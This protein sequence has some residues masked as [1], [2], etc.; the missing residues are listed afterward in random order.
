MMQAVTVSA[1]LAP[2][3]GQQ[4]PA[5]LCRGLGE[6]LAGC[7]IEFLLPCTQST[8]TQHVD[9]RAQVAPGSPAAWRLRAW[10]ILGFEQQVRTC[11]LL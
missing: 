4:G 5:Q 3:F 2:L 1:R 11:L 9:N 10:S 6:D 7:G 8:W